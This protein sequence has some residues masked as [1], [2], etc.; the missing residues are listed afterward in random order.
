MEH[1]IDLLLNFYISNGLNYENLIH[2]AK[3]ESGIMPFVGEALTK[4]TFGSRDDF[5]NEIQKKTPNPDG[6]AFN[7]NNMDFL[8]ILDRLIQIHKK[9]VID[10]RLLSFYS[11]LKIDEK[12]LKNQ[13][14]SLIPYVNGNH[15]ITAN[16]DH[17]IDCSYRLA[18][19]TPDVTH[20]FE[21]KKLNTL[22]RE[23]IKSSKSNIILKIHGDILS[24]SEHRILTNDDYQIHYQEQSD[25]YS[26]I[27]QWLQN[28]IFLFIGVDI[29]KDKY[30]LELLKK[31]RS[32]ETFHYAILGC[33]ND[34]NIKQ[35]TY[36]LMQS[37]GIFPILYDDD[38]P[39]FLEIFLH[40]FLIDTNKIPRFPLGEIDYRYSE[41]DLVGRESQVQRLR[42][43]LDSEKR[44]SWIII[45]GDRMTGRT[46]LVYD[47][48]RLYASDWEWYIIEPEEIDEFLNSQVSIQEERKKDRK[49][50]ISFDNFHWYKGSL[51]NIFYSEVCKSL[52]S[53]KVRFIFVVYDIKQNV[54]W[55]A[56]R[57]KDNL[58]L[59]NVLM[60]S[61]DP[62]VVINPLS[63]DE[64]MQLC[65]GYIYYRR[66]QLGIEEKT[67]QIFSLIDDELKKYITDL[68]NADR[69]DILLL[70]QLKAINL[71]RK[72]CGVPYSEDSQLA[73]FVFQ[74]TITT[75]TPP[76]NINDFNYDKWLSDVNER[77]RIAMETKEYFKNLEKHTNADGPDYFQDSEITKIFPDIDP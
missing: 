58:N 31:I 30:L 5:V 70:C 67:E 62:H 20:P 59:W 44:V 18:H 55:E 9:G 42:D 28:Y 34:E 23:G 60:Q 3:K 38:H 71:V 65:H 15:C 54:I 10:T 68:H 12:Y 56:L 6:S 77:N 14:V 7:S 29:C 45:Q 24:D 53:T 37:I 50:L 17:V 1:Y 66:Y 8:D 25:F 43:F 64:I 40:K 19:K 74:L 41:Q 11:D 69:A 63:V 73:E 13:A 51:D 16:L 36:E 33:K 2:E 61:A 72:Q 75:E 49:V 52:Y 4:C 48:S 22:I 46:K 57:K 26:T 32:N 47:F 76:P 27:S 21:R 39:E 35:H